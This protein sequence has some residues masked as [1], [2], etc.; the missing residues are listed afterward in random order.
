MNKNI[1]NTILKDATIKEAL[2]LLDTSLTKL[3]IV[4]DKNQLLLGAL[5]DGDIRRL[6]LKGKT[7]DDSIQNNY[8]L[9][10]VYILQSEFSKEKATLI[11]HKKRILG[12]PIVNSNHNVIDYFNLQKN[13]QDAI[14]RSKKKS[15]ESVWLCY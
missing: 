1:K 15:T 3:L 7:L 2:K 8:K 6:L 9:N 4:I 10:P 13:E 12:C 5:S 11:C 14:Q